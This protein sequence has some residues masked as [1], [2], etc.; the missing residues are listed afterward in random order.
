[1]EPAQERSVLQST[2]LEVVGGLKRSLTSDVE[3]HVNIRCRDTTSDVG[4]CPD[5]F[6][7]CFGPVFPYSDV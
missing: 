2:K 1:M 7:S 5:G 3:I 6:R 4:D